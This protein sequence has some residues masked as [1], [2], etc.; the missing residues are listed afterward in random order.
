MEERKAEGNKAYIFW[1]FS[2]VILIVAIFIP[3]ALMTVYIDP[4]F[5]Y[6]A[7]LEKYE[8]PLNNQR[9]QN[10]GISRN[11]Q[12]DSIITGT[13]MT[14]NFKTSEAD[15]IFDADFIK[16]CFS[17]ARYKEVNDN[18]KRA[19]QAGKELKY[20]IR[21]LDYST[22]VCDKDAYREDIE[23][24]FWLNND[25][26]F[27]DV[28]YLLNKSI[29][30]GQ[31][32]EVIKYTEAGNQTTDFDEYSNWNS[33][34]TFGAEVVLDTYTLAERVNEPC[35]LTQAEHEMLLENIRQNVTDLAD[36]H[37]ETVFYCFFPPY[38]ICYWDELDNNG[39]IDW[40]IDAE[41]IA[42]EEILKHPNIK[43]YSFSHNFELVCNLDNYKDMAH[44]GEWVNSW[45]L[46]WMYKGEYLLT[47]DN[48]LDYVRTIR[49]FYSSYP[50]DSLRE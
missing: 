47:E 16:V 48:Y 11:F 6:H 50:Y 43:L 3:I 41:Q 35:V 24:P 14:E 44:Y 40:K 8:Y 31:T 45:M 37:P 36:A 28:N 9:Y 12:Y 30:I 18:L 38:S 2:T 23:Y 10:D 5:H 20:V 1:I 33:D 7:P 29:L 34:Y 26:P 17:G 42:I 13:S 21:S 19:Y 22:L 15:R 4:L 39:R 49:E 27:D 25:N 32:L 46:E